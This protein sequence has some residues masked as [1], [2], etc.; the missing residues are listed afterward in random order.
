MDNQSLFAWAVVKLFVLLGNGF[1]HCKGHVCALKKHFRKILCST[2]GSV[3]RYWTKLPKISQ[4]TNIRG[5]LTLHHIYLTSHSSI[6]T[7]PTIIKTL[8]QNHFSFCTLVC[9]WKYFNT[10][11]SPDQTNHNE[12]S[13]LPSLT[14]AWNRCPL[15]YSIV[16]SNPSPLLSDPPLFSRLYFSSLGSPSS[17]FPH[18]LHHRLYHTCSIW[19]DGNYN[20]NSAVSVFYMCCHNVSSSQVA[21]FVLAQQ[22]TSLQSSET[23][24]PAQVEGWSRNIQADPSVTVCQYTRMLPKYIHLNY[25]VDYGN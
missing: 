18:I 4:T 25:C 14:N 17:M 9:V 8:L 15:S 10:K 23:W 5:W 11:G 12:R 13:V 3:Q 22:D 2:K 20:S 7:T 19:L 24:W 1:C 6:Y 21:W 16:S